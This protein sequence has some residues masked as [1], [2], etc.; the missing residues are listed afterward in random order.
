MIVACVV[1]MIPG[2]TGQFQICGNPRS[3]EYFSPPVQMVCEVSNQETVMKTAIDIYTEYGA[4][5][6]AKAFRC[7][8][9]TYSV[10]SGGTYKYFTEKP[11]V[12]NITTTPMTPEDCQ[13]A[14]DY[15]QVRNNTLISKGNGVFHSSA[16]QTNEKSWTEGASCNEG[17]I[18]SLEIG[19][20]ATPDGEKVISPL[21]DMA[22]CQAKKGE[23]IFDSKLREFYRKEIEQLPI[24]WQYTVD[25]DGAYYVN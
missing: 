7:S 24:R 6:K 8:Q 11:N 19:E 23:S 16:S 1:L 15:R 17:V 21:G 2:T 13:S 22:G 14:I 4:S 9:T 3:G 12:V 18:Y 10:C 5:I 20:V 25:H